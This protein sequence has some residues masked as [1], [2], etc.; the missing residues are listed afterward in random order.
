VTLRRLGSDFDAFVLAASPQLLRTAYRLTGDHQAAEDLLQT[1]LVRTARHWGRAKDNP[2]AYARQALVNLT[3]DRWRHRARRPREV[4][5]TDL[6]LR[7]GADWSRQVD[8]RDALLAGL[9]LLPPRQRAVLVLRFW[10]D[11]SVHDTAALLGCS[12]GNVKSTTS[13]GLDHLRHILDTE[14]AHR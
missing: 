14:G 9:R 13:R 3:T 7:A 5:M 12:V 2:V 6:D 10:E 4:Q 8:E 1:T 11:L